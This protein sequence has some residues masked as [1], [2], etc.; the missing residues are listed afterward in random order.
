M[1]VV[2]QDAFPLRILNPS[3]R[4][5]FLLL[6]DH[7]G[8]RLPSGLDPA[9]LDER[10]RGRH[11]G[12]DIGVAG[13]GERLAVA[14]DA[15]FLSQIYSRLVIDC[16]RD[17]LAEDAI[18]AISDGT[19]IPFNTGLTPAERA[20]RVA[21]IHAPYHAGIAAELARRDAAGVETILVSLHSFTPSMQGRERPW[22]IGILHGGGDARFAQALLGLL[23]ARGDLCVGDNEPYAMDVID[24]S[25]PRHAFDAERLYVE[26][27]IRQDL[28]GTPDGQAD[29]S[30]ILAQM[31]PAALSACSP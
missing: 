20:R 4:S 11:I 14:F 1:L 23:M 26:I 25:V 2:A 9:G 24:H 5:Q 13:L 19:P 30:R 31:L 28:L 12:W 22:Q 21:E 27:E 18:P 8:N 17:P 16:N 7:A 6:G 29:W 3:G 15:V 10:D